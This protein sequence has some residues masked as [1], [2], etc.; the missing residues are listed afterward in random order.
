MEVCNLVALILILALAFVPVLL[1]QIWT[2]YA[3]TIC[4]AYCVSRYMKMLRYYS[5]TIPSELA[6]LTQITYTGSPSLLPLFLYLI[7]GSH[8]YLRCHFVNLF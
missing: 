3:H 4:A 8:G 7:P 5:G 6:V 1:P 2:Q